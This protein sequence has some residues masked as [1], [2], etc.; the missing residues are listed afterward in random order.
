[1]RFEKVEGDSFETHKYRKADKSLP[2]MI[3]RDD[4]LEANK[5]GEAKSQCEKNSIRT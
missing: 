1:M 2:E 4:P 5:E 3:I